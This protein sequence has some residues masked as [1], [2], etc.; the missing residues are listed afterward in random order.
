MGAT[1]GIYSDSLTVETVAEQ[2]EKIGDETGYIVPKNVGEEMDGL[3]MQH[4]RR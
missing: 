1:A 2:I 3:L 4:L